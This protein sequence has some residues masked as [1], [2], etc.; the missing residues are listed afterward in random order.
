MKVNLSE[1]Q[2]LWSKK[3][4]F[5]AQNCV[6]KQAGAKLM[7]NFYHKWKAQGLS[8]RIFRPSSFLDVSRVSVC[9]LA[10]YLFQ[11]SQVPHILGLTASPVMKSDPLSVTKIEETLDAI[12]RT[13][14]KHRAELRL[15]VKLPVLSQVSYQPLASES[16][17]GSYTKTISSLGQAFRGLKI[18]EDPYVI[19]LLEE[20]TDRGRR[21]LGKVRMNHKTW[22]HD[23]MKSFHAMT[24][25][26]C[27]E[28]G[29]WAADYYASQVVAKVTKLAD[30]SGPSDGIWDVTSAEKQYLFKALSGV[31][32]SG[33]TACD[34]PASMPLVTDKVKKLIEILVRM[35]KS[36]AFSGIVFVQE[37]ALA[38]VLAHL[39]SVHPET[40][41]LFR[42]G[43]IAGTSAHSHQAQ[44]K[45]IGELIDADSQKNAL[46]L[47]KSGLINLVIATSVLEEGIYV[48]S[49]NVVVRFQRPA[50][51]K[52]FV[53]RRGRARQR[54]SELVLLLESSDKGTEWHQL[55]LAMRKIYEDEMRVLE[56]ILLR[57]DAEEPG[58][59]T[60]EVPSTGALLDF[61][62]TVSHLYHFCSRLPSQDYV[63]LR[64]EF[65]CEEVGGL[66]RATV[67]L[68]LSVIEEVRTAKSE[69]LW[70][71]EKNAIKDAS[72]V[73]YVALYQAGLVNDNLLPLLSHDLATDELTSSSV[74]KRASVVSV[75]EQMKPWV[76][77]A[78]LWEKSED[79]VYQVAVTVG[80]LQ[81]MTLV[82]TSVPELPPFQAYWD[83]D[84]CLTVSSSCSASLAV[85]SETM[86]K[87]WHDTWVLLNFAFG[88]SFTIEKKRVIMPFF[89]LNLAMSRKEQVGRQPI[90]NDMQFKNETGLIRDRLEPQVGYVFRELLQNQPSVH[91]VQ[92][93]YENYDTTP[94]GPHLSLKRVPRRFDFLRKVVPGGGAL[95][96][97]TYSAV[98]PMERCTED[99]IPFKFVQ[100]GLLIPSIMH[101]F[102]V[103]LLAKALSE[104][105]LKGIGMSDLSLIVTA[106]SASSANEASNYQ[107]L[108]FLGDSILK[109]CVS[110]QLMGAYP[111]WHEGYLS[112]KKDRLVSNSRLSRAAIEAGLDSFIITK[113]FK[114]H[115][116]RP[117]YIEDTL[118]TNPDAKREVSTKVL[119]DVV[120]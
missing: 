75:R 96:N 40:R 3:L 25:K 107:R 90:T 95:S 97:K 67:I 114:V 104:T 89:S 84:T 9:Y 102:S 15:Q 38:A 118:G 54:D 6:G 68:P 47:F 50:N 46:A 63:D 120:E 22:C 44:S 61:D 98:L 10:N 69:Q 76:E 79:T 4:T 59:R 14:T 57:E 21:K 93:P 53:Q 51:L 30:E 116:W 109:T 80:D 13:P 26:I 103:Y 35:S 113:P 70:M 74:E 108:E 42:I 2:N 64:P 39:I 65:I 43:T 81:M 77:I 52:S 27:S 16:S 58:N 36:D 99:P 55:E 29:A 1:A 73:A 24:L 18:S 48:P 5:K 19:S 119:A 49:C 56:E 91:S 60:F 8:V 17:L 33:C 105:L 71:S 7:Q 28:L 12:C 88:S 23:Q 117:V 110:V 72:F 106:I 86:L 92:N 62:N 45:N 31:D 87:A 82:P 78:R 112:A 37:R 41:N 115:K 66:V 20:G 32:I 34:T 111:L 11:V 94:D 101:R 100:F 83:A 85:S